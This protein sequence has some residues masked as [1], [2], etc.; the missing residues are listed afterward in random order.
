MNWV[1]SSH[2]SEIIT[3]IIL[4]HSHPTSHRKRL[5][6]WYLII[7][8]TNSRDITLWGVCK[9]YKCL[10]TKCFVHTFDFAGSTDIG[11]SWET[12]YI[13]TLINQKQKWLLVFTAS[14]RRKSLR[15][16]ERGSALK[17]Q[18][19]FVIHPEMIEGS[20]RLLKMGS[21]FLRLPHDHQSV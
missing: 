20:L 3:S 11:I 2:E 18:L 12:K 6:I 21:G 14:Q 7:W 5:F 10:L 4:Y 9:N 19:C 15:G 16:R 13:M 1:Y 8:A 17:S